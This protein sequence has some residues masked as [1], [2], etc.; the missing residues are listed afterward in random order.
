MSLQSF[1]LRGWV[2][3]SAPEN[4]HKR[5]AGRQWQSPVGADL[6]L[7]TCDLGDDRGGA[8]PFVIRISCAY[9]SK[10]HDHKRQ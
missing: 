9:H 1:L 5:G 10:S 6:L 3:S 7:A 4:D 2:S 8:E